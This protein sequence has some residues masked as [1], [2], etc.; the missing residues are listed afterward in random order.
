MNEYIFRSFLFVPGNRQARFHKA[1]N[2]GADAVIIDLE[3]AVTPKDKGAARDAIERWVSPE[4]PVLVRINGKETEWFHD[5][6]LVCQ[7]PGVAGVILPKVDAM[8]EIDYLVAKLG[9]QRAIYP[10]IETAKGIHNIEAIARRKGVVRLIF[11]AIDL[12]LDLGISG[13]DMELL[14]FRSRMVLASR[15]AGITPPV[16]GVCVNFRASE[17]LEFETDRARKLGFG[18]K[19]CIHPDQVEVVNRCFLPSTEERSWALTVLA[20]AAKSEG[21]VVAVDGKMIDQPVILKAQQII[22]ESGRNGLT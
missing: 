20:A 11:G 22:A 16:D 15:L 1:Y 3:D 17:Q 5:D 14:Y 12:Q 8:E 19:L 7:K 4:H 10:L 18:G 6:I 13:D 21:A 9:N 2:A